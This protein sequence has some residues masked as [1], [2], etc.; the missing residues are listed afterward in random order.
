MKWVFSQCISGLSDSH[1]THYSCDCGRFLHT[2]FCPS[3]NLFWPYVLMTSKYFT[4]LCAGTIL[5]IATDVTDLEAGHS[6]EE[7]LL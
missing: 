1:V 2:T 4:Q 5:G 7:G 3:A 6:S